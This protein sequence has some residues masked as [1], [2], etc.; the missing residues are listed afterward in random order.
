MEILKYKDEYFKVF[1]LGIEKEYKGKS[2][3]Y[4]NTTKTLVYYY[5]PNHKRLYIID[6]TKE[7]M[8]LFNVVEKVR[9]IGILLDREVKL[10]TKYL[11][12]IINNNK[13]F[14]MDDDFFI[15]I[16]IT[17]KA[18]KPQKTDIYQVFT[19]YVKEKEFYKN[20]L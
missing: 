7:E 2:I 14:Y 17:L 11:K 4:E 3:I 13:I 1:S 15:D 19:K 9:I 16:A 20:G 12:E 18:K 6:G 10:F 5:M 8:S